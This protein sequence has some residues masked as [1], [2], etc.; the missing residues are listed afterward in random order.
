MVRVGIRFYKKRA[1]RGVCALDAANALEDASAT[2]L[3]PKHLRRWMR[4]QFS[5]EPGI[6]VAAEREWFS[7]AVVRF[8]TRTW[9]C[10]Q[11][12]RTAVSNSTRARRGRPT[13]GATR[14]PGSSTSSS[15][16]SSARRC[17]ASTLDARLASPIYAQLLGRVVAFEDL[18]CLDEDSSSAA[19]RPEGLPVN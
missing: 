17:S 10:L 9:A 6:D 1:G 18:R 7:L 5:D 8:L 11:A 15:G 4:V 16:A 14:G 2:A 3:E 13:S 12:R 19:A